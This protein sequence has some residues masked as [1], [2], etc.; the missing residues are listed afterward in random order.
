MKRLKI[1]PPKTVFWTI[2]VLALLV[3]S[4]GINWGLPFIYHV[5]E[6]RF[7]Q[8]AK[9]YLATGNLNPRFF[10]VPTFYTYS[11]AA[12][13]E[14]YYTVGKFT[15]TFSSRQEFMESFVR[16]PTPFLLLGRLITLLLSVA[17][18]LVVYSIGKRMFGLGAGALA[19]LMLIFSSEHN[20]ISHYMV[21]DSPMVSFLVFSFYFI[22]RIC[23]EGKAKFY[24][25]SGLFAGLAFGTKYGGHLLVLPLL[26]AH[27]FYHRQKKTTW[28]RV[29]FSPKLV[30]WGVIF[31]LV[32]LAVCPYSVLDFKVFWRDFR[33]QSAHLYS[34]GHFGS[35]TAQPAWLFYFQYGFAENIGLLLQFAVY[36]GVILAFFRRRKQDIVLLSMPLVLFLMMGG[37]KTRAVRYLLPIAPFFILAGGSFLDWLS[38]RLS[39]LLSGVKKNL[40]P[41][42]R[43]QVL[44]AI[45]TAAVFLFPS[46]F[47]VLRF[48]DTLAGEDTRTTAK[49][50]IEANI[51]QG[52]KIALESYGP[53]ISSKRYK[54]TQRLTLSQ[55]DVDWLARRKVRYVIVSDI[56]SARFARYPDEFPKEAAFYKSL[57]ERAVLIK[58][59]KPAWDEYLLDLHNPTLKIYRLGSY[60]DISFPGNFS[61]YS[62]AVTLDKKGGGWA[63]ESRLNG[64]ILNPRDEKIRCLYVRITDASGKEAGRLV[65]HQ[66]GILDSG[67]ISYAG[68]QNIDAIPAAANI[69]IGYEYGFTS[70]LAPDPAEVPLKKEF[71]L[72][73]NFSTAEPRAYEAVFLYTPFPNSRGDDYVQSVTL[74]RAGGSWTL[75]SEIRGGELRWGD[76]YVLNPLVRITDG[77]GKEIIK[78]VLAEGK[79]GSY[80]AQEKGPLRKSTA[81]DNLPDGFRVFVG[82]ESYFDRE[83]PERAGGP[84]FIELKLPPPPS[85]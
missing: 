75:S 13:W 59:F 5:D 44:V 42:A 28:L 82:Y 81:V 22:W 65:L 8:I 2:L 79:V 50:W 23:E 67:E 1:P 45:L 76:D 66:G 57:E 56:M 34:L 29:I 63:L 58:T 48:D 61:R 54:L 40:V 3:R 47:K 24:L 37:W 36:G 70:G 17:A 14:G 19:A 41:A 51:P 46:A 26:L 20:K 7:F 33:W 73:Q 32:F 27:I 53:Q 78:W 39:R 69:F 18:I 52:T 4:W 43:K 74:T 68:S 12:V 71:P 30:L 64:E 38:D 16:N 62:Q 60:P 21:P 10:H 6:E 72:A 11:L 31:V 83:W 77:D 80:D 49:H 84:A 15:G 35:S 9:K 85:K 55:V 25:L